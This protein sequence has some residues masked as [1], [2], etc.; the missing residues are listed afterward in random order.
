[1]ERKTE[2]LPIKPGMT[3][4]V[5]RGELEAAEREGREPVADVK[6]LTWF[7]TNEGA[8]SVFGVLNGLVHDWYA[9]GSYLSQCSH[10][11]DIFAL[12]R[13]EWQ[14]IVVDP[15]GLYYSATA[16]HYQT[17][18]EAAAVAIK[19]LGDGWRVERIEGSKR[20]VKAEGGACSP[21]RIDR[22]R[23]AANGPEDK[24]QTHAARRVL[25]KRGIDWRA[26]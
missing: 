1:M 20:L 11:Y 18:E 26:E 3:E 8:L 24:E 7:D 13:Y 9:D 15:S 16:A 14:W 22:L 17:A 4:A 25:A 6:Q 10:R 21:E 2:Y 23:E 19:G 5:T 12:P